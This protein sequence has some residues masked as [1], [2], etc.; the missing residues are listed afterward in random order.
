M[1]ADK[2]KTKAQLLNELSEVRRRLAEVEALEAQ[3]KQVEEDLRESEE[4]YSTLV[5]QSTDAVLIVQ[6]HIVRFG[7]TAVKDVY[8]H[9]VEE[10]IGTP[11]LVTLAP[12]WR[13]LVF[14]RYEARIRGEEVP[15][16]Y[17]AKIR[18]KDGT[19]KDVEIS[20]RTIQYKGERAI[21]AVVRDITH[22][23]REEERSLQRS[24]ELTALHN[25]LLST[26]Q[27]LD[28]REVLEEIV[29]QVGSAVDSAYTAIVLVNQ[30]GSVGIGSE[31]F[32]VIEPLPES[33]LV[34]AITYRIV[35]SG[36]PVVVRDARKAKSI[37]PVL[38]MAGIRSYAG[39]PIRAIDVPIGV[40]FVHGTRPD[41][42]AGSMELLT[43]FAN[44][45]AIAIQNARLYD[46]VRVERSRVE[47]LLK[48]VLTAQEDERRRLS[49]DLHDTVTQSMYGVLARIGAANE[50][51]ARSA[52]GAA[53]TELGYANKAME[54]TLADL[55]RVA[56]NLHPPAL[57]TL[58]IVEALRQHIDDFAL[59]NAEVDYTLTVRGE[60]QRLP[61]N[62]EIGAYRVA[63]E[64]L[65]N[66]RRHSGAT[67]VAVRLEFLPGS[68]RLEVSDNGRGFD[69]P[70]AMT[71]SAINGRMGLAGMIERAEILG[72]S[73]RLET[74]PGAGTRV[75]LSIHTGELGGEGIADHIAVE[76]MALLGR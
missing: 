45:A 73:L 48:Q 74:S 62:L 16:H 58:G 50:L 39:M 61:S 6:D 76:R 36:R 13:D 31:H 37:S 40:L 71:D 67:R 75:Q 66:A 68:V 9:T 52:P 57:D 65:S 72:G 69:F 4:K 38:K 46:T 2:K 47:Q 15:L 34:D 42:F 41:A 14:E 32:A 1:C 49:L 12:E 56:R 70:K 5:E 63:Q 21:M 26:T 59:N 11:A 28:L 60:I 24:R 19:D 43:A 17:E 7:N 53:Q 23:K 54:Q 25:V 8:G 33:P 64:A 30:D 29:F 55:R 3:G 51:L 44:Q 22:R 35:R 18:C 20:G 27:T 10:M